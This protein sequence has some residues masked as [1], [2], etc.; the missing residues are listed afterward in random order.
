MNINCLLKKLAS[1]KEPI[2]QD[3]GELFNNFE[4]N[5]NGGSTETVVNNKLMQ[6]NPIK[7]NKA[8]LEQL[9]SKVGLDKNA[10]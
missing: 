10:K 5:K 8:L 1:S 2:T 9:K 7:F 4:K 3:K 6:K